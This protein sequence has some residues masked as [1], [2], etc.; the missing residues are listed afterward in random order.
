M[1][2]AREVVCPFCALLCDD[3]EV[4]AEG[5]ALRVTAKGCGRAVTCF[6]RPTP[7]TPRAM[8]DG[9]PVALKAAIVRA[10]AILDGAG[11]PLI[12][13]LGTD[14]DGMRAALRLAE[15]VGAA[16]DHAHGRGLSANLAAMQTGGWVTGTLAEARNRADLVLLIGDDGAATAPRLHERVLRPPRTL[17]FDGPPARR[18][19]Q[20]GGPP[21][22]WPGIEHVAC[23]PE[24]LLAAVAVLRALVAGRSPPAGQAAIVP[25]ARLDDLAKALAAARY[26][27]IVWSAGSLPDAR[28]TIAHLAE[29]TR[30]LNRTGRAIGLP[31][32]GPDNVIGCNQVAAWQTGVPLPL[33]FADGAPDHDPAR[34]STDALLARGAVDAL[35]W[36][37]SLSDLEPPAVRAPTVA[38]LRGGVVPARPVE[39]LIPVATPGLD[40][41]GTLYR[42]DGVVALPV[43]ALRP[44][45]LPR[46]AAVLDAIRAALGP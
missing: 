20:L 43:R 18:I 44:S 1:T 37:S 40:H 34:W 24:L 4:A 8:V 15:T 42:T 23:A 13:G 39:V 27:V 30:E 11:S 32:A 19:V 21:S 22:I 36:L 41:A 12:A 17:E 10:A 35:L 29:L 45:P 38:L 2:V 6:A 9:E 33:T 14:T 26:A 28:P 7:E 3:L 5:A 31:L 46:A 25:I 16:L